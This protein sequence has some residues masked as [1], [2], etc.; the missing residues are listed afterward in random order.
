MDIIY[1]LLIGIMAGLGCTAFVIG[2]F[3]LANRGQHERR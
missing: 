3:W 1:T 2:F